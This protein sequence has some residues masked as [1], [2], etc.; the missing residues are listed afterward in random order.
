M[1][2]AFLLLLIPAFKK[3]FIAVSLWLWTAMFFP[4]GWVYGIGGAV[5]YNLF[6]SVVSIASVFFVKNKS[7]AELNGLTV[8]ISCFLLW[9]TITHFAGIADPLLADKAWIDFLKVIALYYCAIMILTKKYHIDFF[10]WAIV[11]SIGFFATLE[12][13][14]VIASGGGHHVHGMSGHVLGDNNDLALAINM[15]IPLVFYLKEQ[16]KVKAINLGLTAVVFLM[17][18][19]VLGT[20]SRGGLLGLLVLGSVFLKEAKN[21]LTILF[22]IVVVVSVGSSLLPEEWFARMNTIQTA[23]Q[24]SSFMGRVVAWKISTLIALDNPIMGGGIKALES[25][26]I[27]ISYALQLDDKLTFISTPPPDMTHPHAAHSCYFQVLGDQGFVGLFLF[28]A[29]IGVAYRKL[30]KCTK[31]FDKQSPYHTLA[32]MLKL[33]IIMFVVCGIA[34]SKVYFDLI[35]AVY[36]LVRVLERQSSG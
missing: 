2:A 8:L 7:K 10:V 33:S 9:T 1:I 36:A 34:L 29:V 25:Y 31:R 24:D 30:V 17:I 23:E 18:I 21:K 16:N 11:L 13:L 32:K 22:L 20:Q 3:P 27:W 26:P 15:S 4:N 28:L 12:G 5:R 19:C 35:Y 6:F 14:K